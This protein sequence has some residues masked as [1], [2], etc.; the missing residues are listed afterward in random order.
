MSTFKTV[1]L[2]IPELIQAEQIIIASNRGP[3]EYYL[4]QDK[5]LEYNQGPGGLVTALTVAANLIGA[6]WI[7]MAMTEGDLGKLRRCIK[8]TELKYTG[9]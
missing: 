9:S 2:T 7:A 8:S 5:T 3:L 1:D 4:S 6:T